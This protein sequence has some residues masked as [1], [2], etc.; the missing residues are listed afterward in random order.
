MKKSIYSNILALALLGV[1]LLAA[2]GCG[3]APKEAPGQAA[4]KDVKTAPPPSVQVIGKELKDNGEYFEIHL[5]IPVIDG[6][7]D[8]DL[9]AK[10]N[11]GFEKA[12]V[13]R[14]EILAK[15]ARE[16]ALES[17]KQG[18]PFWPFQLWTDYRVNYNKNGI[19]SLYIEIYEYTGGAHGM[20]V[21]IPYNINLKNGKIIALKEIFREGVDYRGVL[22]REIARQI[23]EKKDMFFTQGDMGFKTI[24]ENQPF[25]IEEGGMVVYFGLY[26]ISPYAA[27]IPEFKLPFTL[28]KEELNLDWVKL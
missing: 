27:G 24:A 6:L 2:A 17:K 25:Y 4:Q 12:V 5:K 15:E 14:K 9:Q 7:E 3:P 21:R 10:L 20:T 19:L 28:F 8:K 26:E 16:L 22:N 13:D 18:F 1:L 23:D 11:A